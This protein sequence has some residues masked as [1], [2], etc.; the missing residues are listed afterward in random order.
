[1]ILFIVQL[2]G[3]SEFLSIISENLSYNVLFSFEGITQISPTGKTALIQQ[4]DGWKDFYIR[5]FV[6]HYIPVL[7]FLIYNLG[8]NK[9][10]KHRLVYTLISLY[11]KYLWCIITTKDQNIINKNHIYLK[12]YKVND[13]EYIIS[14]L[15]GDF[16]SFIP[17][18]TYKLRKLNN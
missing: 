9:Q 17:Y 6:G 2:S 12:V 11:I 18:F 13:G 1:M 8:G 3:K 5:N 14:T 10:L 16:M 15:F 7:W 4:Y